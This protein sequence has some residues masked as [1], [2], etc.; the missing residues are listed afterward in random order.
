MSKH[1]SA[2]WCHYTEPQPNGCPIIGH[3]SLMVAVVTHSVNETDQ[4]EI[5]LANARLITAS[6]ELLQL[7]KDMVYQFSGYHKDPLLIK[8][9]D[10]I[11]KI[12]GEES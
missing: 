4:R 8:A 5:A 9:I 12:Q 7:L 2:P 3:G 11:A 6:P 1:T 10:L